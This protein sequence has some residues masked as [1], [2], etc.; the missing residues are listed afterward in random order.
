MKRL[1]DIILL[2]IMII[3]VQGCIKNDIPYPRIQASFTSFNVEDQASTPVIDSINRTIQITLS[4]C[5]NIAAVKVVDYTLNYDSYIV[6]G[7]T[8]S[9][10]DLTEPVNVTLG[11]YQEYTWTI[12]ATQPVERYLSVQNQIGTSVIDVPGQRVVFMI[13][14]NVDI[15]SVLVDS[16]KLGQDGSVMTPDLNGQKVDFSQA[17]AVDV[18][19]FGK[20][21]TWHIYADVTETTVFTTAADAWT[22][23]AWI[24]GEAEA[25][26]DNGFEY[27]LAGSDVWSEVPEDW[28]TSDG[29][30]MVARLIHLQ[31]S[32]EY[33]AR[34]YSD[35][36][37]GVELSFTTQDEAQMPDSSFDTWT[38]NGKVW[39]PWGEDQTPYWD[40][41]NRG[42][43]TLGTANVMPTDDTSTGS[44]QA[45]LL[46]TEFK[47]IGS[48]GKLAAGSLFAGSYVE[49]DGTN[50][51]LSFGQA[52]TQRPTKLRGAYKYTTAPI[53]NTQSGLEYMKGQPDTCII[54]IALID[55]EEPFEIR[56][57]PNN[58]RLF[59]PDGDEV[60]AYGS[61]EVG[62]DVD[63]Y[64]EFEITLDY[65]STSR[66]PKYILCVSSSSKYGD[67]FTG[68]VGAELY[69]DDFELLF[70]Y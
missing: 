68:G 29:G 65:R 64:T 51:I 60:I 61:L 31:P 42:A 55:S 17:V 50:G 62:Y 25:G 28:I 15:T 41:G 6:G 33:V 16:I 1:V 67:Y 52:F 3:S 22:N 9:V 23:V 11:L 44:G 12:S 66:A 21:T 24:Y 7:E 2:A 54:W 20:T 34:A 57:N 38:L 13:P 39:Q 45:A 5:A 69:I 70:D 56:T 32:T 49:T 37:Y 47:G 59:D 63:E 53:S 58:R 48:I 46:K 35:D 30:S 4:E 40:T 27:R 43:T 18:S 14:D 10:I 8:L 19:V 36:Q 26:K